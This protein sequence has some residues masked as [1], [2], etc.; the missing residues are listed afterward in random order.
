MKANSINYIHNGANP[1]IRSDGKKVAKRGLFEMPWNIEDVNIILEGK[2]AAYSEGEYLVSNMNQIKS[3]TENVGTFDPNNPDIRYREA[4]ITPED[5]Q[6][7]HRERL[8]YSNLDES[9]KSTL[10]DRGITEEQYSFLTQAEKENMRLC[11]I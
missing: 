6:Q 10:E 3:A 7:Y 2:E 5:I 9:F 11:L 4:D 8:D 1:I